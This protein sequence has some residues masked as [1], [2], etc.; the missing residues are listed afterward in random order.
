MKPYNLIIRL[1]RALN[2]GVELDPEKLVAIVDIIDR[3]MRWKSVDDGFWTYK[4]A[5]EY[6]KN[7]FGERFTKDD[8][9]KLLMT[10]LY[11]SPYLQI[12]GA[13]YMLALSE[14]NRRKTGISL[15]TQFF[16]YGD[17]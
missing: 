11:E 3:E 6:I 2:D 14:L 7:N 10:H 17:R 1:G 9:Y 8:F 15:A 4:D 12:I 5:I 16:V 13:K